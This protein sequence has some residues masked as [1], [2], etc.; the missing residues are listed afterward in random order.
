MTQVEEEERFHTTM[1]LTQ[2]YQELP[3]SQI[4]VEPVSIPLWFSRN[5]A[6]VV[7][8]DQGRIVFPYHYGSHATV[9]ACNEKHAMV[10]VSI[11]LW[12]SR[13]P[14]TRQV[15]ELPVNVSIPLWFSRNGEILLAEFDESNR[16]HTTMVL[17]Q[18]WLYERKSQGIKVS[19]PLWFSRNSLQSGC[20]QSLTLFPYHYGSHATKGKVS[21]ISKVNFKFPYHYGSHATSIH[22]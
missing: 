19:I 2:L 20:T 1:V 17:T 9:F 10:F 16:F 13:N 12:F 22:Y 11:P 3:E 8:D 5:P 7:R 21:R 4:N 15:L 14:L 6:S 18:R